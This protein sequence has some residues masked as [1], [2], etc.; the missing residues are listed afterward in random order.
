ME[1]REREELLQQFAEILVG[2][3]KAVAKRFAPTVIGETTDK[4][5]AVKASPYI[6]T[7]IDGRR[8]TRPNAPKGNPTLREAIYDWIVT[9]NIQ[10]R[11]GITQESLSWAISQSIHRYGDRLYQRGGG[12]D[13]FASVLTQSRLDS[14]ANLVGDKALKAVTETAIKNLKL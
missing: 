4:S 8:P 6:S 13:I 11:D 5:V 14:F 10:G 2:D 9:N 1:K 12:N 7:L 3:V